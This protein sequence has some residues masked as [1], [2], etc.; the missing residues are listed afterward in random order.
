V[1]SNVFL[2]TIIPDNNTQKAHNLIQFIKVKQL[3]I[4]VPT[5]FRYEV[6]AVIRNI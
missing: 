5:L 6:V 1:D 2:A 4:A 3:Q